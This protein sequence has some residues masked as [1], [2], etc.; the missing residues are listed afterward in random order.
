MSSPP[1][2]PSPT[3][4]TRERLLTWY[5]ADAA[6][7][8]WRRRAEAPYAV[9]VSEVMLQQTQVTRVGPAFE[10][11]L[12]RFPD[13]RTLAAARP[14]DVLRAWSGL[15]YN[16]RAVALHRAARAIVRDHAGVVPR[17]L[18]S[19]RALPGVGPYTAAAVA[20]IAFGLPVAAI[21]TNA[22]R[23]V[24]RL[25]LGL[26]PSEVSGPALAAAADAMVARATPGDWN[27]A[28]M[29]L[30]RAVCRPVPRCEACPL[31][32]PCVFRRRERRV[33]AARASQP[34][35]PAFVGSTRQ[36]RGSIVRRLAASRRALDPSELG[37]GLDE[38]DRRVRTATDALVHE[39][40]VERTRDGRLRLPR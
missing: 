39:G 8:P 12:D 19:L 28:V 2:H 14:A 1:S 30:G 24:G 40:L 6:D 15:G 29:D 21:D 7:Y 26:E 27:Q 22:R 18:P 23:V 31:A 33:A 38:P 4:A 34:R 36:L 25:V 32:E 35:S 17:D 11:F 5:R 10:R 13:V 37:A 9:L 16:R 3:V 20:S